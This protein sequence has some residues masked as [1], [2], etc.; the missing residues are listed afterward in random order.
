MTLNAHDK[1]VDFIVNDTPNGGRALRAEVAVWAGCRANFGAKS[2]KVAFSLRM[3]S[4]GLCRVGFSTASAR[5][6]QGILLGRGRRGAS[7]EDGG[8]QVHGKER[9]SATAS[10][11]SAVLSTAWQSN[12]VGLTTFC[13]LSAPSLFR[14]GRAERPPPPF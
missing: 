11:L 5:C 7:S 12:W 13:G 10:A 1:H 3:T 8:Q 2:G 9:A 6:V 4:G 14:D